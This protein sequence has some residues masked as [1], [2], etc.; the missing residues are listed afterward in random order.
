MDRASGVDGRGSISGNDM[1]EYYIITWKNDGLEGVGKGQTI[2]ARENDELVAFWHT[3]NREW[4]E[5]G[6][7]GSSWSNNV[8]SLLS[9][10]HFESIRK[11]SEEE[12]FMEM[13]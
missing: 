10:S 9:A 1:K 8:Q 5:F 2:W 6:L 7:S 4:S 3:D 13:I 11:M 12:F